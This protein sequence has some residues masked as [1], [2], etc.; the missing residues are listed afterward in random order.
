MFA[1]HRGRLLVATPE[2]GDPNFDRTVVLLLEHTPE[3]AVGV[4]LNRP[5]GTTL[6]EAGADW[7][8]WDAFAAP[9]DVVFVGG[10]VARTAVIAVARTIEGKMDGFQPVLGDDV[11]IVDLGLEPQDVDAVRLFAGYAGWGGGQLEAEISAGGW[12]V[13]EALPSDP[14]SAD[15][16]ELWREV[17]RRQGGRL[18][19]F[20]ACP[21]DPSL[22]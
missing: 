21:P 18:A 19:L 17:L 5:S 8:G 10:P 1:S 13:L 6:T 15:P 11:G 7:G 4:V 20:A 2:L 3:G 12:F 16:E 14:L 9:P 22:N